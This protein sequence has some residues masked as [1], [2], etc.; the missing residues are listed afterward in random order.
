MTFDLGA[1]GGTRAL[2]RTALEAGDGAKWARFLN[3]LDY[4]YAPSS[5]GGAALA[6]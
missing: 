6:P 1:L 4:L 3:R 5:P 2:V